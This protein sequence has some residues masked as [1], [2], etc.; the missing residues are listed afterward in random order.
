MTHAP[1]ASVGVELAVG[2]AVVAAA[3][4][5]PA[6]LSPPTRVGSSKL[7]ALSTAQMPAAAAA[8]CGS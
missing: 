2:V 7:L 4:L 1:A 6:P 3:G 8:G 5:G